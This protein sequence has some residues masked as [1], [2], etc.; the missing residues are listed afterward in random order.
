MIC[1]RRNAAFLLDGFGILLAGVR[2]LI[3]GGNLKVALVLGVICIRVKGFFFGLFPIFLLDKE[4]EAAACR[5]RNQ[6]DYAQKARC[7]LCDLVFLG[8]FLA[9]C[10]RFFCG[11]LGFILGFQLILFRL[12][13]RFFFSGVGISAS[14]S[15]SPTRFIKWTVCCPLALRSMTR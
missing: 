9:G 13:R 5:Q 3:L 4:V 1:R 6:H 8:L 11:F 15:A 7:N 14:R 10:R 12:R 2:R